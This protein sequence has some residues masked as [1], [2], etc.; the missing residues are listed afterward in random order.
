MTY[1]KQQVENKSTK[2]C[3]SSAVMLANVS[4]LVAKRKILSFTGPLMKLFKRLRASTTYIY[5]R[6]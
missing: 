3:I 5:I 2:G 6:I 4:W 1:E